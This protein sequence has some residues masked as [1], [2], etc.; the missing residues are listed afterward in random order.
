MT[1]KVHLTCITPDGRFVF[2]CGTCRVSCGHEGEPAAYFI[3]STVL[4]EE[5][6]REVEKQWQR[7]DQLEAARD[8]PELYIRHK[9]AE[10]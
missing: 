3:G 7:E 6:Y 1:E 8:R 4:C 2:E 10:D 5:H 9:D